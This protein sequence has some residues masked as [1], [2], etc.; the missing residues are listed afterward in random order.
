MMNAFKTLG[1]AALATGF[2]QGAT[3]TQQP[4]FNIAA[5]APQPAH[6]LPIVDSQA[7]QDAIS[8]DRLLDRAQDLYKIAN[9][10]CHEYNHP[11]RVIGSEGKTLSRLGLSDSWATQT[12]VRTNE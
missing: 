9:L 12:T 8:I 11:T 10:S 3:A 5:E 1:L 2:I 7:L 6:K 4:L